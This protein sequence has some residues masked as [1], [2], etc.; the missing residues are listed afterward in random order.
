MCVYINIYMYVC[1]Y[2]FCS[3]LCDEPPS[4]CR[5]LKIVVPQTDWLYVAT[6]MFIKHHP[7]P[8]LLIRNK[9][10]SHVCAVQ[11]T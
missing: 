11:L 8:H 2:G 9:H 1:I 5:S 4:L 7:K 3:V 6:I 10:I